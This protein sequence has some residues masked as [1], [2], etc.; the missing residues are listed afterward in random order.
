TDNL[1]A[2]SSSNISTPEKSGDSAPLRSRRKGP[3]DSG[4]DTA[5]TSSNVNV[6]AV[7]TVESQPVIKGDVGTTRAS[8]PTPSP[9]QPVASP[10]PTPSPSAPPSSA[11]SPAA[12][13]STP[14]ASETAKTS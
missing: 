2:L 3:T 8:E 11:A 13:K 7:S 10:T 14:P 6:K 1:P 12:S 4:D 9:P 5:E